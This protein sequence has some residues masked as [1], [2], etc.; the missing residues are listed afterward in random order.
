MPAAQ[1][2]H[3]AVAFEAEYP[4][5]HASQLV[6]SMFRPWPFA[7]VGTVS[8]WFWAALQT[9]PVPGVQSV[10]PQ[11]HVPLLSAVP[12]VV[13]QVVQRVPIAPPPESVNMS[14]CVAVLA[15]QAAP[16]SVWLKAE[17]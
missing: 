11:A 1:S 8:H 2:A 15:T 13:E 3:G 4:A 14:V 10:V 6:E 17:A 5:G 9:R 12:S 16:Q 7:Q